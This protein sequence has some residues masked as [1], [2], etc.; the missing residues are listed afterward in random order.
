MERELPAPP[1]VGV[2][3]DLKHR[4]PTSRNMITVLTD[5][6]TNQLASYGF[7]KNETVANAYTK[8]HIDHAKYISVKH[9]FPDG[10][11]HSHLNVNINRWVIITSNLA[12]NRMTATGFFRP[13]NKRICILNTS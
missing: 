12:D 7:F 1:K 6:T 13:K 2:D 5:I 11:M 9:A 8:R 3:T 4:S 10:K